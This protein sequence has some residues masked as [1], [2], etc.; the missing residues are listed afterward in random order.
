M[1]VTKY[2]SDILSDPRIFSNMLYAVIIGVIGVA[3]GVIAVIA[4]VSKA[5]NLG[6]LTGSFPG[7]LSS[8]LSVSDIIGLLGYIVLGLVAVWICFLVSSIFL[9]RSYMELGKRVNV[10]L[11]DTAALVYLIGAALTIILVGFVLIF[12][13]EILF[14]VA[15]FSI[16]TQT[17]PQAQSAQLAQPTV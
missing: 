3:V 11:F 12:V 9:R 14:V 6:Y 4:I 13:A 1:V 5:I 8:S 7:T 17:P 2:A 10:S 16:G 15:F